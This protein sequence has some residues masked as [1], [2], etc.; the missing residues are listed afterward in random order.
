MTQTSPDTTPGLLSYPRHS[1]KPPDGLGVAGI[2]FLDVDLP[3][4]VAAKPQ[5][6]VIGIGA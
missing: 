3:I 4:A 5:T 6:T 2:A 1:K